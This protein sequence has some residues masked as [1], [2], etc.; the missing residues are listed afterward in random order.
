MSTLEGYWNL[1]LWNN[2]W[3]KI[4]K[5]IEL[6]K[7]EENNFNPYQNNGGT[8]VSVSGK[9]FCIVAADTRCSNGF[10]IPTRFQTKIIKISKKILIATSGM[11]SDTKFLQKQIK[12]NI[13]EYQYSNSNNS[14][15]FIEN[16]AFYISN[17]LYSKRFF[18]YYTFNLLSG[19]DKNDRGLVYNFDAIGSFEKVKFSSAGSGQ[20]LIQPLLDG[21]F[22]E[23]K[24]NLFFDN[25]S[26]KDFVC[27]IREFF[28]KASKRGI[29]IGDGLQFFIVCK[30]G[31]LVENYF[32]KI[33]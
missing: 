10:S 18:P 17:L 1:Y 14:N 23:K 15:I 27:S 22:G 12:N 26:I 2:R 5:N 33:D 3:N 24:E 4:F 13:I 11:F 28:L 9:T 32:L 21:H 16:C 30:K 7:K 20:F 19:L 8:V 25:N 31:I 6:L 29:H